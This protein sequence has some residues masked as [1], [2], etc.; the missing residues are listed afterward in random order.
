MTKSQ[1]FI[2]NHH[3]LKT[4]MGKLTC[5]SRQTTQYYCLL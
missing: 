1:Q 4:G 3:T 5:F 2:P